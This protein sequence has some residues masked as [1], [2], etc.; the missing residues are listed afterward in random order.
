M[1]VL[2]ELLNSNLVQ[3]LAVFAGAYGAYH[4]YKKQKEDEIYN[5]SALI[6]LEINSIE[7]NVKI[8]IEKIHYE[9]VF[10]TTPIYQKLDWFQY[11]GIIVSKIELNHIESINQ[12]YSQAIRIEEARL[13]LKQCVQ[14]NRESKVVA[15]QN[16]VSKLLLNIVNE[17]ALQDTQTHLTYDEKKVIQ[18][19]VTA[20][21][22]FFS[23]LYNN[24]VNSPDHMP[25][26]IYEFF[27]DSKANYKNIS[28]T[29]AYEELRKLSKKKQSKK[30][31]Q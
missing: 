28:N 16:D 5:I 3:T 13:A 12:F 25:A 6:E 11:R 20:K 1:N 21:L 7:E 10:R 18:D 14:V 31:G 8:L 15:I 19:N 4:I 27:N 23:E 2:Y 9:Q 24:G 17:R 30:R 22:G 26:G 29:P